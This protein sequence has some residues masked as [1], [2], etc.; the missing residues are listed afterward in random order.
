VPP[1][2]ALGFDADELELISTPDGN[3]LRIR[4]KVA[5]AAG[6]RA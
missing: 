3:K 5:E 2:D 1:E 4:T 6:S